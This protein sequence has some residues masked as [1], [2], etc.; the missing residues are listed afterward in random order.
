MTPIESR[1]RR[2]AIA[3]F[4][5]V[6]IAWLAA[7]RIAFGLVMAVSMVRFLAYGFVDRFFVSPQFHFK[8]WGF[9]WVEP[10]P[11]MLMHALFY[12]MIGLAL[13]IASGAAFRMAS[14]L[15]ALGL[16]YVQ[17]ID[18]STY[19][20]HYYLALLL[21]GLLTA[22]P[23]HRIWSVDAWLRPRL[24]RQRI[25]CLWLYLFRFQVALVYSFAG[26]AKAQSDWLL[27]A[28]PLRIW[29]GANTDLPVLGPLFTH[30]L[31]PLA[32]SWCGFLFD[33][34]V[35]VFLLW[36][37]T[38]PFAYAV[39]IGFHVLTRLLFPIGMF[40]I[41]MVLS[42]LVFF[43]PA[44][45]RR[46]SFHLA[47]YLATYLPPRRAQRARP[48]DASASTRLAGVSPSQQRRRLLAL[49]LAGG[50]AFV[51]LLLPLRFLAYGGN[52]LWHEQGM[53]FAWRVMLR[54]KGGH[55]TFLVQNKANGRTF[56]VSPRDY[57]T[58]LQESEM[59]GQPDLILQLAHHIK[60]DFER[61]GLGPVEVR[62]ESRVAL[63]GRRGVPFIDPKVDLTSYEDGLLPAQYV[64][65]APNGAPPHTRPVF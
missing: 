60:Q 15:F 59:S 31:V 32:M 12:A 64:L 16:A 19:L 33:S 55:T 17:L 51:Q 42:A 21:A 23:A 40:P 54:A 65:P 3:A 9:G 22:S 50:Y 34:S 29:L 35:V 46:L 10:L 44:W 61:R 7:F 11:P 63:N 14:A 37:R 58:G 1:L 6:D 62:A 36:S 18:V 41:I 39:V 57:L 45:P 38:R 53:R 27:H 30:P 8:Y 13:A 5:P 52:V 47:R 26:L 24:G 49:S 48:Y 25:P 28:Q 2:L 20:N 56:Y 43:S 4:E